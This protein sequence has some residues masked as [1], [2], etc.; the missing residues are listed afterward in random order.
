MK[1]RL[2]GLLRKGRLEDDME[3]ELR[4]HL[5][6]RTRENIAR[7]M[8][9]EEAE[10]DARRHFG[11]LGLIKERCR[12]IR[13]GGMMETF[14][15]DL[16][17]GARVLAKHRG[18]TAVAVL[19]LAL[20]IGAN[21]AIF[22]VVNELLLRPLPFSDAERLVMV[23]EVAPNGRRQN[24]TSRANFRAWREQSTTFA[25]MA[26][27]SDQRLPLTG[28]GEP[29]EVSVQLAT[30]ELFRVLGVE[31]ILGRGLTEDDARTD[32]QPVIVLSYGIWQRRF[33][34]DPQVIGKTITLNGAPCT[35]IGVMPAGFQWH[36]RHRSGTGRPA[37][38]WAVLPMPTEGPGTLG[39]FLS[40]VARLKPGASLEQARAEMKTIHARREQDAPQYNR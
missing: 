8:T 33:G 2:Y 24:T 11:N 32:T 29:E 30:P 36:I 10:R 1:T 18:F 27:F 15:Q 13:G 31:P 21:T 3:A 4:F 39:R 9:P 25:G 19:T 23:W 12:D 6:M 37:E 16:R 34:G 35:V 26:A 17:Y 28:D 20:G 22:S 38:I 14:L 5:L 7:G 40:V